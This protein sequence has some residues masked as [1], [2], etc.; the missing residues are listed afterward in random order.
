MS[1]K[2][3]LDI[4]IVELVALSANILDSLFIKASKDTAK[5]TFKDIKQGNAFPLG[6]VT[7]QERIKPSLS[8]ALDYSEFKGPGFNFDAFQLA[9][10]SILKQIDIAFK[11]KGDLNIMSS[12]SS[13][14]NTLLFHLPGIITIKDQLNAMVMALELGNLENITVK[15]MFLDPEQYEKLKKPQEP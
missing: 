15:L 7:I 12:Q 2:E 1:D 4:N 10:T 8:L 11:K 9:L 13:E 14:D 3:N 6:T 5:T